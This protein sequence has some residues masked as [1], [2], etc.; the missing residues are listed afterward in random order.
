MLHANY[1]DRFGDITDIRKM[2]ELFKM[3]DANYP[4]HVLL[5]NLVG[6]VQ[7]TDE[8]IVGQLLA[9]GS[10]I[11]NINSYKVVRKLWKMERSTMNMAAKET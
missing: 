10:L 4:W 11:Y 7:G 1:L 3:I 8:M 6:D 5:G 9:W 2:S